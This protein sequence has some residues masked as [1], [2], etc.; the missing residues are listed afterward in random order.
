MKGIAATDS[1][2]VWT[3]I[4]K[5]GSP[6]KF[7]SRREE[8]VRNVFAEVASEVSGRLRSRRMDLV[9][10]RRT[11]KERAK[12]EFDSVLKAAVFAK[13]AGYFPPA[14]S[15]QAYR[16]IQQLWPAAG[17]SYCRSGLPNAGVQR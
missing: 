4:V 14:G 10:D 5:R 6:D 11:N 8:L 15:S 1:F 3:G 9:V 2:I 12:K 13:H 16:F 17:R 7:K